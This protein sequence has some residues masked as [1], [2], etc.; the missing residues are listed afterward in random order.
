MLAIQGV[1]T[2]EQLSVG[3]AFMVF[4]QSLLPA[5]ILPLCNVI[6]VQSLRTNISERAP[7]VDAEKIIQAG[8]TG[9]RELLGADTIAL[10]LASF[11]D[12]VTRVFYLV[13][14]LAAL[15]GPCLWGMGWQDLRKRKQPELTSE[16]ELSRKDGQASV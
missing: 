16:P 4:T 6:L 15:G 1:T 13:A 14:A 7:S 5:I 12:S 11:S 10:V 9:F 3:M 8:A 2:G